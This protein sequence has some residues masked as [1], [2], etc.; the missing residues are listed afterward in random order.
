MRLHFVTYA[1]GNRFTYLMLL[2]GMM[3]MKSINLCRRPGCGGCPHIEFENGEIIIREIFE[4][5]G[6]TV[7]L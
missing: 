5:E 4:C 7:I 1:T 2:R 3:S 6:K